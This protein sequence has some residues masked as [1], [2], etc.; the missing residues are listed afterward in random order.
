MFASVPEADAYTMKMI[1]HDWNDDECVQILKNL[2]AASTAGA[3][4]S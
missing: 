3:G 2:A 4:S 1:L